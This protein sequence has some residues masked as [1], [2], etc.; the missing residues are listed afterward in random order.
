M[1]LQKKQHEKVKHKKQNHKNNNVKQQSYKNIPVTPPF[2][3]FITIKDSNPTKSALSTIFMK[4][5]LILMAFLVTFFLH[6]VKSATVNKPR[7]FHLFICYY[8]KF[9]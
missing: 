1:I 2:S 4:Y 7:Y 9:H 6:S 3:I 8:R 5:I